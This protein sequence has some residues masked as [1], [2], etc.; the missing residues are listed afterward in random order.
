[1]KR[2]P[3]IISEEGVIY[4]TLCEQ[5][6]NVNPD[7]VIIYD[8]LWSKIRKDTGCDFL[9]QSCIEK[10]LGRELTLDDLKYYDE[11]CTIMIPANFKLSRKLNRENRCLRYLTRKEL[12]DK[13]YKNLLRSKISRK[14]LLR[15]NKNIDKIMKDIVKQYEEN[16]L[17][18][19]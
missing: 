19:E 10:S 13:Y 3:K 14:V 2:Y 7:M 17:G 5:C 8:V 16:Y 12:M 15:I 11:D 1:M 4:F 6:G 18:G 9:C